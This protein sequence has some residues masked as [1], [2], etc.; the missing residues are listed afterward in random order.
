M[1]H[2]GSNCSIPKSN[3]IFAFQLGSNLVHFGASRDV[4]SNCIPI[5]FELADSKEVYLKHIP[6]WFELSCRRK[7]SLN[8][9]IYRFKLRE[10]FQEFLKHFTQG[11]F[12]LGTYEFEF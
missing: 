2:L 10:I 1:F 11:G 8:G 3:V 7:G 12:K 4:C 9:N 5:G 6:N